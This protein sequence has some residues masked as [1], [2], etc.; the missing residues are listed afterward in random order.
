VW[1]LGKLDDL[2]QFQQWKRE[3]GARRYTKA[4]PKEMPLS[5]SLKPHIQKAKTQKV[6]EF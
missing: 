2:P 6:A 1:D 4:P 3:K 5:F